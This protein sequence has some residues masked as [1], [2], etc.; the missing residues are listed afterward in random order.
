MCISIAIDWDLGGLARKYVWHFSCKA[1]C[2]IENIGTKDPL[3]GKQSIHNI[4]I[5]NEIEGWKPL[6]DL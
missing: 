2:Q 1:S 6:M 4:Q 3:S 5:H